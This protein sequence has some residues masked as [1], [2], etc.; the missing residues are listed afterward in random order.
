[1]SRNC[2]VV[3]TCFVERE[4]RENTTIA[5]DPP[6]WFDHSQRFPDPESV[7]EL[8][9]L[10]CQLE[11]RVDPGV[12]CDTIIVNND[13]GW[14]RGNSFLRSIHDTATFAG[15]FKVI[16]R[17]NY[18]RSFGGYN[19]AYEVFRREY[20]YWTFTEDDIL[21]VGDKYFKTCI[22]MFQR[23]DRTG[24]VAIQGVSKQ[25]RLQDFEC[26]VRVRLYS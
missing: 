3:T 2:K 14:E 9:A 10:I 16:H 1:M 17:E 11:R 7:L 6:G 19:R 4:I 18:G 5:G 15:H 22:E 20:E 24:F 8:C 13:V 26:S 23:Q 21:L 12:E 25:V